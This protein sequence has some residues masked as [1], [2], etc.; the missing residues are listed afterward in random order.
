MT[1]QIA[2]YNF[3][4]NSIEFEIGN[5]NVMINATQM[6]QAFS[7]QVVAFLRNEQTKSFIDECLKSE[8]SHFLK[9]KTEDDLYTSKQQK[10]TFMHRVLALKFAAWLNPSFEL[11]VYMKIE[12]LLFGQYSEI[13]RNL[14]ASASRKN[15]IAKLKADLSSD[16][17]F[18]EYED[19]KAEN[20]KASVLRAR[21]QKT[22][23][24][25]FRTIPDLDAELGLEEPTE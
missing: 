4:G 2:T 21:T 19:L 13:E 6:A 3:N 17:R 25:T 16:P 8:N 15:R 18:K 24:E 5:K 9:I 20:R 22:Q 7:K 14:K 12:Y 11:W 1:T 10:G 23:I